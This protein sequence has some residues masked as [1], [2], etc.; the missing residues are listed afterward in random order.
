MSLGFSRFT[1]LR[2]GKMLDWGDS[3]EVEDYASVIA[4]SNIDS[5]KIPRVCIKEIK[6]IIGQ[7]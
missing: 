5:L 4:K 2:L 1:A 7:Q 3:V 6:E